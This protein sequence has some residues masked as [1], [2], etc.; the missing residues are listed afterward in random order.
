MGSNSNGALGQNESQ[1][2][3]WG[4]SSPVQIPGTTWKGIMNAGT[5]STLAFK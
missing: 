3:R 5:R 4:Y 1:P 2:T